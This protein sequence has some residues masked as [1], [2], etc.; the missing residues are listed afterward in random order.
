MWHSHYTSLYKGQCHD[1]FSFTLKGSLLFTICRILYLEHCLSNS[2]ARRLI[3]NP[4]PSIRNNPRTSCRDT[5]LEANV[6]WWLQW[7]GGEVSFIQRSMRPPSN[8]FIM[9]RIRWQLFLHYHLLRCAIFIY[10]NSSIKKYFRTIFTKLN[11]F[12]VAKYIF[13]RQ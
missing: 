13:Y 12:L 10:N 2:N 3:M 8:I 4:V 5:I 6:A 1:Y 7:S 11:S 9:L